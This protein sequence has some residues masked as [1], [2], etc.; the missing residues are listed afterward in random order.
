MLLAA[1]M[2]WAIMAAFRWAFM[3]ALLMEKRRMVSG[4]AGACG[5]P[6]PLVIC[7]TYGI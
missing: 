6:R 5:L 3:V 2:A 7:I 4:D 1:A